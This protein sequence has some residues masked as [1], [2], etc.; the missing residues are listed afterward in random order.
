MLVQRP[1][2]FLLRLTHLTNIFALSLLRS[3]AEESTEIIS[4]QA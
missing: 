3:L 1:T 4:G 2:Q